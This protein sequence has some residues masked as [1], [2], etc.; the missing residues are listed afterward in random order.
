MKQEWRT[1]GV[2]ATREALSK[3]NYREAAHPLLVLQRYLKRHKPREQR[4]ELSVMP[5][6]ELL[7]ALKEMQAPEAYR[8][9]FRRWRALASNGLSNLTEQCFELTGELWSSGCIR[10]VFTMTAVAPIAIGLGNASPLE[11]GITLHH[12]YGM[13]LIP[14]S[15]LKGLCRRGALLL[16]REDKLS[17]EKFEFLFGTGGD[18]NAAAGA[19]VFYDAWYDPSSPEEGEG[20]PFHRDVITVHHPKY[21]RERG[22]TPPTDFDDPN[23]VPFLVIK[24]GVRFLFVLDA[25]NRDCAEYAKRLLQWCLAN[26]GVGAKT[27]AGYGY[28]K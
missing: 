24:P 5:E 20:K 18:K 28:L 9:A 27:N 26:L 2:P 8:V 25:V 10:C 13:P 15:A 16:M 12:T 23:P 17:K 1:Q 3:L 11:V 19:V 7:E 21:Y 22:K 6:E 14:G 4:R